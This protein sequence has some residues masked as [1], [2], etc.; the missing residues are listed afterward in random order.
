VLTKLKG[1]QHR[2][3]WVG[4]RCEYRGM[5]FWAD[6]GMVSV[7]DLSDGSYKRLSPLVFEER[8][9]AIAA[10]EKRCVYPEERIG[11]IE[12]SLAA[13]AIA[14]QALMQGCF[15]DPKAR[16]YKARH[17]G[18]AWSAVGQLLQRQRQ[19]RAAARRQAAAEGKPLYLPGERVS[20]GGL[21]LGRK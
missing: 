9:T 4:G 14:R 5:V 6:R 21:I 17:R 2:P 3:R 10:E 7:E 15:F 8:A 1:Q 12:L 18:R 19:M 20:R 11:V 16:A 13:K